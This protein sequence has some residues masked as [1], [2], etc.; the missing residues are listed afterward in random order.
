MRPVVLIAVGILFAGMGVFALATP[1]RLTEPFGIPVT[2]APGR[3]EV[4]AV[5]GGFGLAVA[6]ALGWA[7]FDTGELRRGVVIVI[8]IALAG[9]AAGRVISRLLDGRVAFYP[10]WFYFWVEVAGAAVLFA[11][12]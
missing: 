10:I 4:R 2:T 8:A 11:V 9:M 12:A 6:G 5:Y 7:A 3:S 1:A